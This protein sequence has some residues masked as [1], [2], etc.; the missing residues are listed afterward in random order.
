MPIKRKNK[1]LKSKLNI[2]YSIMNIFKVY[3]HILFIFVLNLKKEV[4]QNSS[5]NDKYKNMRCK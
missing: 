2:E 3:S 5:V 1:S 4:G